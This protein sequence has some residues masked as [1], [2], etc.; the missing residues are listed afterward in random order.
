[1]IKYQ[2]REPAGESDKRMK[3]DCLNWCGD[4]PWL[5]DG[6]AKPC[7]H[8]IQKEKERQMAI[9]AM[10][11]EKK[12]AARYRWLRDTAVRFAP[13]NKRGEMVWCVIGKNA[14][15]C[16]PCE[17]DELDDFIDEAMKKHEHR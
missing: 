11:R 15:Q 14:L 2:L 16:S 6:R 8:K 13:A 1:M 10:N 5:Q 9:E 3:C 12:D 7:D 17:T 4:D